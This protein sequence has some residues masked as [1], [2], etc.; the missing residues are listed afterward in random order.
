MPTPRER[1]IAEQAARAT[2]ECQYELAQEQADRFPDFVTEALGR[3]AAEV[4]G[5]PLAVA[6]AHVGEYVRRY[7]RWKGGDLPTSFSVE[8]SWRRWE[9]RVARAAAPG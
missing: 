9:R 7:A 1:F 8:T 3:V 4:G 5:D 2:E 6:S